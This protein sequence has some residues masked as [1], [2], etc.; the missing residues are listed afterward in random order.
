M[1]SATVKIETT[2]FN[3]NKASATRSFKAKGGALSIES[4]DSPAD[5]IP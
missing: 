3:G 4:D 5:V 2:T 1:K